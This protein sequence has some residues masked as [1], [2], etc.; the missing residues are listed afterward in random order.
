MHMS[1]PVRVRLFAAA[2]A[3]AGQ[4]EIEILPTSVQEI[5]DQICGEN[6]KAVQVFSRCSILIDGQICHDRGR[7]LMGGEEMDVL[8]PFAG[9]AA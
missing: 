2:R 3:A 8:P 5:L 4:S 7:Q 9:G 1:R 6:F